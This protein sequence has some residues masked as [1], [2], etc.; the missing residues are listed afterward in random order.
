MRLVRVGVLCGSILAL[1]P[2]LAARTAGGGIF[3]TE[4]EETGVEA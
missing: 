3:A 4:A 2:S 1:S